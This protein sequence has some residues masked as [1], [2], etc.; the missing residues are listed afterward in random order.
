MCVFDNKFVCAYVIV[1]F[2]LAVFSFM[3]VLV[4]L[5]ICVIVYACARKLA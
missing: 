5:C 1:R 4:Y 3:Y 2:F